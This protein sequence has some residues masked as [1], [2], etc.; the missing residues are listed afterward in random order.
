MAHF[1]YLCQLHL[2]KIISFTFFVLASLLA[3]VTDPRQRGIE[4][5]RK[6]KTLC[7]TTPDN[8]RSTELYIREDK[9]YLNI[10]RALC[11]LNM[12]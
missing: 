6:L 11:S 12:R 7:R 9:S 5:Q 4:N 8:L 2:L 3:R 10:S 1:I